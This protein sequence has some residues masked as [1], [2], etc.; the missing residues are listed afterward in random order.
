MTQLR[1]VKPG[2]KAPTKRPMTITQAVAAH[3]RFAEL[4]AL[5]VRLAEAVQSKATP[6]RDLS[7]L[8]RRQME[9]SRE[10]E[11]L[12]RERAEKETEGAIASDEAWSTEAI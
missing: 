12:R 10:L 1:A 2:E 8:T 3:D 11:V 7:A 6:T 4:E 9:V 5:H